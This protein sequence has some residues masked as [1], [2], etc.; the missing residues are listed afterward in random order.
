MEALESLRLHPMQTAHRLHGPSPVAP[1]K[2]E[3]RLYIFEG[4]REV[5]RIAQVG[6][7]AQHL[8]VHSSRP[9]TEPDV[10]FEGR[11]YLVENLQSIFTR[12]SYYSP[13][14]RK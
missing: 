4:S 3:Q 12:A 7:S 2:G 10:G 9:V 6:L 8:G 13:H 1:R 5:A 11:D 14:E